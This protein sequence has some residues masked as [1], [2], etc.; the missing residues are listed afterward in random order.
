[1]TEVSV[2]AV[3]ALLRLAAIPKNDWEASI[4]QIL[5]I[6]SEVL[7]L[8]RV[9]Y[10]SVHH[11]LSSIRCEMGYIAQPRGFERG[12]VLRKADCPA[13]FA[14]VERAT[15]LEVTDARHDPRTR[16]LDG[17]LTV[18]NISSVLDVP[19]WA[20]GEVVGVLC[21]EHTGVRRQWKASDLDFAAA[22][23]QTV[24]GAIEGCARGAAEEGFR[25]AACLDRASRRLSEALAVDGV[26]QRAATMAV[27]ALATWAAIDLL[28]EGSLE[29]VAIAH[30]TARGLLLLDE[31]SQRFAPAA[32]GPHLT[33]RVIKLQ[34]VVVIPEV[35]EELLR[36]N[37]IVHEHARMLQA[38]GT[39][40]AIAVPLRINNRILGAISLGAGQRRYGPNDLRL[41]EEYG[42]RVAAALDNAQLHEQVQ[43][44]VRARDEFIALA[45]QLA[46]ESLVKRA[47]SAPAPN[48]NLTRMAVTVAN[49]TKRLTRL[50]DHM[51]DVSR[52][53][54]HRLT[55]TERR[56]DL[57]RLLR[58]LAPTFEES[59]ARAHCELNWTIEDDVVGTWD[60]DRLSQ[61]VSSLI[62][63]AVKFGAGKPVDI[64]LR[65]DD[66]VAVLSV[67]DQ[68]IGIPA[69]RIE[70]IFEPFVRAV[71]ARNFGGLGLGLFTAKAITDAHGGEIAVESEPNKGATL[72]VRLPRSNAPRAH[73]R[74]TELH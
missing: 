55:L 68:G 46:S 43:A 45:A 59:A 53:M 11:E 40:S 4:Q 48:E 47:S 25:K 51:L 22:V 32:N 30:A 33:A 70:S 14:E 72:T 62:D 10:W 7:G 60:E 73:A 36:S 9:S 16:E 39:R 13:Y 61:L 3:G 29:R 15:V 26:A 42:A 71:S 44:A 1:M 21:H 56:V 2:R 31:M 67:R 41:C 27:P 6:D 58:E 5:E 49:Q 19:V 37:G 50:V 54:A 8:Q 57:S 69:D 18:R 74:S 65:S 28:R 20:G 35:T 34:Q 52:I 66:G 64:T 24:A 38:L 17:Y 23:A 63:N 12:S